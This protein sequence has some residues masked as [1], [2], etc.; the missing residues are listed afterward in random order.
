MSTFASRAASRPR[1]FCLLISILIER[2]SVENALP[3][4]NS[5][6]YSFKERTSTFIDSTSEAA[7]YEE[8]VVTVTLRKIGDGLPASNSGPAIRW[9]FS[10]TCIF[11]RLPFTARALADMIAQCEV[12]K[13]RQVMKRSLKIPYTSKRDERSGSSLET[14]CMREKEG[15]NGRI[16]FCKPTSNGLWAP[17][18]SSDAFQETL[19]IFVAG[20]W[21]HVDVDVDVDCSPCRESYRV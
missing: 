17:G 9:G 3:L 13:K 10:S 1:L 6:L 2:T 8:D 5:F 18:L 15:R 12:A 16:S 19:L 7:E 11:D 21:I 20:K 4:T 14:A